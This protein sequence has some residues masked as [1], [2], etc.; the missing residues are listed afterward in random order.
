MLIYDLRYS[1]V[2]ADLEVVNVGHVHISSLRLPYSRG[3]DYCSNLGYEF[4]SARSEDELSTLMDH[5]STF[6]G[7]K[8]KW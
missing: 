4:Y 5:L 1:F 8:G 6:Y 2:F 3:L 7:N